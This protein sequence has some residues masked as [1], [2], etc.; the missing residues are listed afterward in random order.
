MT[1]YE[2]VLRV[3]LPVAGLFIAFCLVLVW[4]LSPPRAPRA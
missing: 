4:A 1:G 2:L 3:G